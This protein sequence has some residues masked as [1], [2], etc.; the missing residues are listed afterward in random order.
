[1][2][3]MKAENNDMTSLL[4]AELVFAVAETSRKGEY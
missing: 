2:G 3:S 1:M 4:Q